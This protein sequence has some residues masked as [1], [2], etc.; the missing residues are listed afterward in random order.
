MNVFHF[1]CVAVFFCCWT[2]V[3]LVSV[4]R[5]HQ[6][7]VKSGTGARIERRANST[8]ARKSVPVVV[9]DGCGLQDG[10]Q[11]RWVPYSNEDHNIYQKM[12]QCLSRFHKTLSNHE[13]EDPLVP[14]VTKLACH[15]NVTLDDVRLLME[16]YRR[17]WFIGDSVLLQQYLALL[18]MVNPDMELHDFLKNAT[19]HRNFI[20]NNR[21]EF[22][23]SLFGYLFDHSQPVLYQSVFPRALR[24]STNQDL[25]VVNAG[26]HYEPS[27]YEVLKNTTMFIARQHTNA[28]LVFVESTSQEWPTS[29][30][31][32]VDACHGGNCICEP[33]TPARLDG[34]DAPP[35][36]V[37]PNTIRRRRIQPHIPSWVHDLYV[38]YTIPPNSTSSHCIPACVPASWRSDLSIPLLQQPGSQVKIVPLF[39]QLVAD[40]NQMHA[41][42]QFDCTH[43]NVPTLLM[44]NQQLVRTLVDPLLE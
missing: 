35:R 37:I 28:T 44:M 14:N 20:W 42:H 29:N 17:V 15:R 40:H 3:L 19:S 43:K 1:F 9:A 16:R 4:L 11:P 33:L 8:N 41:I 38:N 12:H 39:R 30:G 7:K 24:T 36:F 23:F 34:H 31:Q 21:T 6:V 32:F 25:I 2:C 18:C 13:V 27:T 10:V 22:R 5:P 26:L